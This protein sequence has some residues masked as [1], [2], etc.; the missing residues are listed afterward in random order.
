M[1]YKHLNELIIY[2]NVIDFVIDF[3][4]TFCFFFNLFLISNQ[5]HGNWWKL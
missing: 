1:I 3:S 2:N 4:F 5:D